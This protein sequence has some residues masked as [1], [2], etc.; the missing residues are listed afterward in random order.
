MHT[1]PWV[2][3]PQNVGTL[4]RASASCPAAGVSVQQLK[5]ARLCSRDWCCGQ[6]GGCALALRGKL[7]YG[8]ARQQTTQT[9]QRTPA[10]PGAGCVLCLQFVVRLSSLVS[11]FGSTAKS[12][13]PICNH[14][15][16]WAV[17]SLCRGWLQPL[18][19]PHG[20]SDASDSCAAG[21][22]PARRV[23]YTDTSGCRCLHPEH[24]SRFW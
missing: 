17:L 2:V 12:I 14:R 24:F 21:Q 20:V 19:W 22:V 13:A 5:G 16:F 23:S 4:S 10:V 9:G 1:S 15:R 11:T 18:Q 7:K 6:H 3:S 8:L